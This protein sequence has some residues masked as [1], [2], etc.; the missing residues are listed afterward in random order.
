MQITHERHGEKDTSAEG[1]FTARI[2][3][4]F[5]SEYLPMLTAVTVQ[6]TGD[7]R[8]LQGTL[9]VDQLRRES[10]K[11]RF[12]LFQDTPAIWDPSSAKVRVHIVEQ[13]VLVG[14]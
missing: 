7:A 13:R 9:A 2:L 4:S 5:Q 3:L 10:G 1:Q 11:R 12:P 8:I 6:P 14:K